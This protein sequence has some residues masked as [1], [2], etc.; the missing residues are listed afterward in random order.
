[1]HQNTTLR[2]FVPLAHTQGGF[3][4]ITSIDLRPKIPPS[5]CYFSIINTATALIALCVGQIT[6]GYAAPHL[7]GALTQ[8]TFDIL[9]ILLT[10]C[11]L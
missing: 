3:H 7:E 4:P 6:R 8:I 5:G 2:H 11:L 1:M 9:L 10:Y